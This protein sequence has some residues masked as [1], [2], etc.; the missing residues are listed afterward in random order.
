M[1]GKYMYKSF[2]CNAAKM[3]VY[4]QFFAWISKTTWFFRIVNNLSIV[5]SLFWPLTPYGHKLRK[6][7]T[8]FLSFVKV[9]PQNRLDQS[10]ACLRAPCQK[11]ESCPDV[12]ALYSIVPRWLDYRLDN[13]KVS[14]LNPL[15]GFTRIRD[16][17]NIFLGTI[18]SGHFALPVLMYVFHVLHIYLQIFILRCNC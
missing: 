16:K 9:L 10:C 13:A 2:G 15:R 4:C 7:W 11:P 5:V 8:Q 12:R 17:K 6:I 1:Y 14:G 3:Y 18:I